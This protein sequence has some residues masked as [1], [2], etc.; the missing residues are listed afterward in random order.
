MAVQL[1]LID[2]LAALPAKPVRVRGLQYD[3]A[4]LIGV[5]GSHTTSPRQHAIVGDMGLPDKAAICGASPGIKPLIWQPA[6]GQV[7]CPKCLSL[8]RYNE[9]GA[10]RF[11][12]HHPYL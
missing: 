5:D 9:R 10:K 8:L 6:Y 11:A 3:V 12:D 4:Y 7:T 1:D 2:L